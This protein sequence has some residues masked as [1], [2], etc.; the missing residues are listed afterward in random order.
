MTLATF[1]TT[2][3]GLAKYDAKF[4][5]EMK[6]AIHKAN[7]K[8]AKKSLPLIR[9]ATILAPPASD[10]GRVGAVDTRR[11]LRAWNVL[12]EGGVVRIVNPTKY[13]VY[14]ENGRQ[15][16]SRPPPSSALVGWVGRKLGIYGKKAQGVAFVIARA[17]GAR[18]LRPRNI[19]KGS[20]AEIREIHARETEIAVDAMLKKLRP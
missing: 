20:L 3:K 17:I 15:A 14:V 7:L 2:P 11:L 12:V 8:A 6:A 10:N 16:N 9:K 5:V 19:V 13:A 18:G 1:R 4:V